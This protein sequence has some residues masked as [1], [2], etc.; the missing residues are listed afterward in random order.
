[1]KKKLGDP[2]KPQANHQHVVSNVAIIIRMY[3]GGLN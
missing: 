3:V 2:F 1:M